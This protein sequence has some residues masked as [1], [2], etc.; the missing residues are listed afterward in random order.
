MPT[1]DHIMPR[2]I[3]PSTNVASLSAETASERAT[4]IRP[5]L[6]FWGAKFTKMGVPA[7]DVDELPY[8]KIDAAS[9][10]LGGEIRNRT[11][12]HTH[13]HTNSNR[14]MHILPIGKRG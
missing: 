10:I 7:L 4:P 9:F 1:H 12:T 5:I 14:Y 8:K 2:D 3:P 11:N 13:T 6:G